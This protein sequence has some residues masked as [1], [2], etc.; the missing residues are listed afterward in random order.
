MAEN[1]PVEE[2][3][4]PDSLGW[5]VDADESISGYVAESRSLALS[6]VLIAPLLIAYEV[7]LVH[8]RPVGARRWIGWLLFRLFSAR[9]VIVLNVVVLLAFLLAVVVL[10]RRGRLKLSLTGWVVVESMGWAVLLVVGGVALYRRLSGLPLES[11]AG[12]A[13]LHLKLM[14]AVGAGIYEELLFRLILASGL[15]LMAH[16]LFRGNRLGAG[17]FAIVVSAVIFAGSHVLAL[18]LR[19]GGV[20]QDLLD[21]GFHL[22]SG[23]LFGALY[24]YRG[25]GIAV[26]THVI[27][28]VFV[29]LV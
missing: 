22:L 18:G 7:V 15:Y 25:L 8:S 6:L 3:P 16:D 28:D 29:K 19:P 2:R 27:Y 4:S 13:P 5:L 20:P 24:V 17:V 26:Y 21:T 1:E 14:G 23:L 12:P 9:G 11:V 10:A